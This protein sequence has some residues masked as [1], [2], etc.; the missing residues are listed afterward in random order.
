MNRGALSRTG[1]AL[2][3][4][5]TA[6]FTSSCGPDAGTALN[7][8][9]GSAF[10]QGKPAAGAV[11]S[12]HK[13]GDDNK[14]NLPHAKVQADGTFTLTSFTSG[15]GAPVGRYQVTIIWK[16]KKP[17]CKDDDGEWVLPT[18]YLAASTSGL[19]VEIKNGSNELEPFHLTK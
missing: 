8:V 2:A 17:G 19:E 13:V 3:L 16:R 14:A 6:L 7:A 10:F 12:F 11:I 18:R 5:L 1:G 15:D 9:K 4:A